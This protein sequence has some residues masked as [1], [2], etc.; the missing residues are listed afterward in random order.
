M[1]QEI[2]VTAAQAMAGV[3]RE[4]GVEYIFGVGG[5]TIFPF[6]L[7]ACE[8]GI[9]IVHARH[10][11]GAAFAADAYGR[12]GR[13]PGVVFLFGGP[14]FTNACNGIA[15]AYYSKSPMVVFVGQHTT[16]TDF[17]GAEAPSY[18][19]EAAR[20]FT[21]SATRIIDDRLCALLTK[22]AFIEAKAYPPGPVLLEIPGNLTVIKRPLRQ[23][24]G[25]LPDALRQPPAVGG[26][27]P[28]AVEEAVRLLRAAERPVVVGGEGLWWSDAATELRELVELLGVPVIT[29]RI[30]RGAVP[31]DHPLAFC[32]RVRGAV[33]NQADLALLVGLNLGYLEG[34][35]RWGRD[36]KF[37]QVQNSPLGV[38]SNV[39]TEV[40]LI[41]DTRAILQQ[42]IEAARR[43]G[44]ASPKRQAWLDTVAGLKKAEDA[45][46]VEAAE[47]ASG[48]IPIHPAHLA[49]EIVEF[50]DDDATIGFDAFT[51]S[52]YLTER[53]RS[54]FQGQILDTGEW[55]TVG[56]GIGMGIGAQLARPGK[57]VFIMMGDGGL[58]IGG[59]DVETAVR[60]KL[61]V[62][63]LIYNNSSWLAGEVE[64]YYGDQMR[65]PDGRPGN[66]MLLSDVRYDKL[67]ETFG[68]HVEHV[69]EPQGI[70]PA[71]ER[72]FKSGKTSVIN[73]VMDRHVYHPMT[74]RIGAA[75]R[76]MDP[77]RMP[78]MGRRL[79]YPELFEKEKEGAGTR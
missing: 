9:G 17:P 74:L 15:Q 39:Q 44:K 62:V 21:K 42:I 36:V 69:T 70:R 49:R 24:R 54:R 11:Q 14:G 59:M 16:M 22:R 19:T 56:H 75:H 8:Q 51:G 4:E 58:G 18:A 76:F 3:L 31:E 50:L 79:A 1:S 40:S 23:Q 41:G 71:L 30:A 53:I 65:L 5:G 61:P 52:A 32:G 48:D 29:R 33:L 27:D 43:V 73:V 68:C 72:S 46:L 67:F 37:I 57:Q 10:E 47:R 13:R 45:R 25:Y 55:V 7:A 64:I 12:S 28:R 34:Y 20:R 38:E 26:S 6:M 60:N 66:P 35:G 78:E 63:Y 2:E 77:A